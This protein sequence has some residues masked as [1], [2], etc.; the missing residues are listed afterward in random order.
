MKKSINEIYD[1]GARI[2]VIAK[3]AYQFTSSATWIW[4]NV[5]WPLFKIVRWPFHK[6]FI[7]YV[8]FFW[9]RFAVDKATGKFI[10]V[11]GGVTLLL[12]LAFLWFAALPLVG[13]VFDAGMYL[14][15]GRR[16][17]VYLTNSQEIDPDNNVH[18]AQGC[19]ALPCDDSNSIYYRIRASLFNEV[20]SISHGYGI[21]YPDYVAAAIPSAV[22]KCDVTSYGIRLKFFMRS[23][24]IYPDLIE[25]VCTPLVHMDNKG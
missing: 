15:T 20:W 14:A 11:R 7:L 24:D 2:G 19:Y 1:N 23:T 16:E 17:T 13:C 21:F 25:S 4:S 18:S 22:S 3:L 5:V 8:K 10:K 6:A 12:T 9:N